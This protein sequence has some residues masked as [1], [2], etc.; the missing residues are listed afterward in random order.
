MKAEGI[1]PADATKEQWLAAI[2]KIQGAVDS[3]QIRDITGND[4]VDDAAARRPRR[5]D[6]LVGRR[7]PAAADNPA[8]EFRMPDQGCILWSDDMIIPVGAPNPPR[9]LR[10]P[11][12]HLRPSIA[13]QIAAY[14][15][16]MTPVD[17]V[18]EVFE[19]Q[20]SDLA[21]NDLIFP[22]EK[23][24]AKCSTQPILQGDEEHQIEEAWGQLT[25]GG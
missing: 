13:A 23:F 11:E 6:R 25:T 24:T 2:D 10:V 18:R 16:Y 3:G 21:K 8:I 17:G 14:V 9:R 19:K 4:Y 12:L 15:N 7:G 22:T 20:G 1:D 5:R